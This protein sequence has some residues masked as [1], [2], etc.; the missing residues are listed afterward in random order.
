MIWPAMKMILA[1]GTVMFLFYLAIRL[2]RRGGRVMRDSSGESAVRLLSAQPIGPRKSIALLAVENEVLVV[3]ITESQI[4]LLD[5]ISDPERA[6]RMMHRAPLRPSPFLWV[7]RWFSGGGRPTVEPR[8]LN[9][10]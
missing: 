6:A 8:G 9:G 1:L 3:G 5:K 10:K 2:A 7:D 4:T